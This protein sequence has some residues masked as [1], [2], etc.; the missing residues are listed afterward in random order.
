ML[1]VTG[2]DVVPDQAK[3]AVLAIGNFDGVHRGHQSL[4]TK[5]RERADKLDVMAGVIVFEPHPRE[6]FQP[7]EPH[8]HLTPLP[9][10]LRRLEAL[11]LDLVVVLRFD[12]SF[13]SLSANQFIENVLVEKLEPRH[14][15]IG[16]DFFFGKGRSG[17]PDTMRLAAQE[18]GFGVTVVSPVAEDGEVFSSTTIRLKLAQGDVRGATAALGEMWRVRGCVIGGAKRGTGLG[19]PTANIA[20]E[21]GTA[22][23]HGIYAVWV[24]IPG[25]GPQGAARAARYM[26]AAY[27]GTRPTFDDG[28]P[29]LEIYLLD[30]DGDLYGREIEVAFVDFIR[31]DRRFGSAQELV[32]QMHADCA[33]AREILSAEPPDSD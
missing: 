15:V 3:G 2:S 25:D 6:F 1:V 22:L 28:G 9:L 24:D 19:F 16:Y 20:L 29:L 26:G 27:L 17:T 31:G 12:K 14:V 23:A 5:V 7:S 13:A 4:I 32:A 30:F 18:L 11:G 10:K 21:R 8:F 33:S